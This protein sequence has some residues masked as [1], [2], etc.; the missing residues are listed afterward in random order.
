MSEIQQNPG[1]PLNLANAGISIKEI[2]RR[3]GHSRKL[4]RQVVRGQRTDIFRVWQ[5]SLEDRRHEGES[6]GCSR[7]V[8]TAEL[9]VIC[10]RTNPLSRLQVAMFSNW[11]NLTFP[12]WAGFRWRSPYGK[13]GKYQNAAG[14]RNKDSGRRCF[15]PWPECRRQRP[16][17]RTRCRSGCRFV[18]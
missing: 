7:S 12:G 14:N 11:P 2:V 4:V 6:Y 1:H 18:Q 9:T 16:A 5:S 15:P 13:M 17:S 10:F 3:T 8:Q